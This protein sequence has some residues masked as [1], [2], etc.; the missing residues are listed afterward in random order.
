MLIGY[1]S[2]NPGLDYRDAQNVR[3]YLLRKRFSVAN[4]EPS[5]LDKDI[6]VFE[7]TGE[8]CQYM[9]VFQLE[10]HP[11]LLRRKKDKREVTIVNIPCLESDFRMPNDLE[12]L[13]DTLITLFE[14]YIIIKEGTGKMTIE[15]EMKIFT[16]Y[17][18]QGVRHL[19][20][21]DG[22]QHAI[23]LIGCS[24]LYQSTFNMSRF[25][26]LS[27][28]ENLYEDGESWELSHQKR[29]ILMP[30]EIEDI[31]EG[32]SPPFP[33]ILTGVTPHKLPKKKRKN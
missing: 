23:R 32:L 25:P 6:P 33:V 5:Y 4:S 27:E 28:L 8:E 7:I 15:D 24:L 14:A 11:I 12:G 2:L 18:F 31:A 9:D 20:P 17:G 13:A 1:V 22:S 3:A 16:G 21:Q 29:R 26:F 30:L 19:Q 10:T